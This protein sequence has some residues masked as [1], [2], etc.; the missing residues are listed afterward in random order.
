M[1]IACQLPKEYGAFKQIQKENYPFNHTFETYLHAIAQ[2]GLDTGLPIDELVGFIEDS[3]YQ[4][5]RV[6]NIPASPAKSDIT[7]FRMKTCDPV[8]TAYYQKQD[9]VNRH[10]TLLLIRMTL[11]LS[12]V[13]GMSLSRLT[14]R[15]KS[16]KDVSSSVSAPIAK[17]AKTPKTNTTKHTVQNKEQEE[18][19]KLVAQKLESLVK[20]GDEA[21]E[22]G[23]QTVTVNANPMLAGFID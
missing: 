13:C 8:I 15:I 12:D 3:I 18:K 21:L 17:V 16:L 10:V 19:K 14:Y 22:Q 7:A 5:K 4:D 2:L 6:A 1:Y 9:I 20:K 23:E 11:R